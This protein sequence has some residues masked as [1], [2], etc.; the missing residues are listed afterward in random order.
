MGLRAT[1]GC[2]DD[3]EREAVAQAG[4]V[5]ATWCA[6]FHCQ[7]ADAAPSEYW[8]RRQLKDLLWKI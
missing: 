8:F 4:P 7:A 3:A 2:L 6:V 5:F 1:A